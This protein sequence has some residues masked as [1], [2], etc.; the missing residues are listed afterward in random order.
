MMAEYQS[1]SDGPFLTPEQTAG[2]LKVKKSTLEKW[3]I[4]G[5][6][7]AYRKHGSVIVYHIDD[8]NEWSKSRKRT[9]T[10]GRRRRKTADRSTNADR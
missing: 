9:K 10:S 8:I 4:E 2:H 6:G 3:R 5:R 1:A 7:P